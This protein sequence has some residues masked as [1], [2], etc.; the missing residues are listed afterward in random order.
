MARPYV[1]FVEGLNDFTFDTEK[2]EITRSMVMAV[3]DAADFARTRS[4]EEMLREIN[5]PRNYL[6]GQ[7]S[8]LTVTQRASQ[9]KP[10]AVITGRHRPTSLA[11]FVTGTVRNG[12]RLSVKPGRTGVI[13][14]AFLMPLNAG[15]E[16][17]KNLGL[18]VRV[19]RGQRPTNAYRP[20][21]IND[22]LWL[23]YGP[24]VDQVFR[25]IR[26]EVIPATSERMANEFI[27]LL[28]A[29]IG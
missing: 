29:K 7:R 20:V 18:A 1:M 23:L 19:K 6:E 25:N 11:R 14:N 24:S 3:N 5:F 9:S 22:R 26:D 27:R 2:A 17:G 10:E 4:A 16:A 21:K 8:R 13:N 28:E 15:D 12:V